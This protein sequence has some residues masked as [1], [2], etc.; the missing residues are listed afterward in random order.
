V[1]SQAP[2]LNATLSAVV[3][4]TWLA[5]INAPLHVPNPEAV[6]SNVDPDVGNVNSTIFIVDAISSTSQMN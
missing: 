1:P 5:K 4:V 3:A 2:V 6:T